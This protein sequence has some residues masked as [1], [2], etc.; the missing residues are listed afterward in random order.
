MFI[1][2]PI[3]YGHI[4]ITEP[5]TRTICSELCEYIPSSCASSTLLLTT[6]GVESSHM[7]TEDDHNYRR[8][9]E[10][11]LMAEAKKVICFLFNAHVYSAPGDGGRFNPG[12]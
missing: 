6:D 1:S 4:L 11:W 12:S 8:G 2:F 3:S 10:W 7:H 9:Y 5:Q